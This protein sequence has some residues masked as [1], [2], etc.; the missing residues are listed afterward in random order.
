MEYAAALLN[1][2]TTLKPRACLHG[3]S[4]IGKAPTPAKPH[5]PAKFD[6]QY[7]SVRAKKGFH[8]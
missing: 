7:S 8:I 2:K 3:L 1:A 4:A 5:G 6:W